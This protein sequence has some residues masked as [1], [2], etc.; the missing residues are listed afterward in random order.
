[1]RKVTFSDAISVTLLL[2]LQCDSSQALLY[3]NQGDTIAKIPWNL[4]FTY[5]M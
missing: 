2:F 1:M 5:M 3:L 4:V